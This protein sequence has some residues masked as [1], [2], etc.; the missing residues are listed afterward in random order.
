MTSRR[1]KYE[2]WAEILE[3]CI[4]ESKTQSWL[5]R[6]LGLK[7]QLIKEDVAF[8]LEAELL[9]QVDEPETGI[10]VF[11]TTEKGKEALSRFYQLVS[12]YFT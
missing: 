11:L 1:T 3:S 8:L 12:K 9:E 5:M 10:Y 7:T 6:E 4:W 2:R